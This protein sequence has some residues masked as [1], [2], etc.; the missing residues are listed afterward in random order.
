MNKMNSGMTSTVAGI[1][2]AMIAGTA[3]Y[4]MSDRSHSI[5]VYKRQG[6]GMVPRIS[7]LE[8]ES[9][10]GPRAVSYTHL[11]LYAPNLHRDPRDR[12]FRPM[13]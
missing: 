8:R 10:T 11:D 1:T 13:E 4:M 9:K 2:V 7:T 6:E 3:A 12:K 5:D